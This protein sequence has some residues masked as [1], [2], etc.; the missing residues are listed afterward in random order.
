[1]GGFVIQKWL[2]GKE[3]EKQAS[4]ILSSLSTATIRTKGHWL[5]LQVLVE[6][7]KNTYAIQ[8]ENLSH[9]KT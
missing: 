3:R 2:Q 4:D 9:L 6:F 7:V 1:M 8:S 5:F